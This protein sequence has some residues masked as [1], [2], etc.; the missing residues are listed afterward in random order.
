MMTTTEA[1]TRED[2]IRQAMAELAPRAAV[3]SYVTPNEFEMRMAELGHPGEVTVEEIQAVMA[4]D[5]N[6]PL[7]LRSGERSRALQALFQA[8]EWLD[9]E[10]AEARACKDDLDSETL[11]LVV[12]VRDVE[13]VRHNLGCI[14]V[15]LAEGKL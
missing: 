12:R 5:P 14:A 9:R 4:Q 3:A 10:V 2:A 13:I 6:H 11:D 7:A 1:L 8:V 15:A